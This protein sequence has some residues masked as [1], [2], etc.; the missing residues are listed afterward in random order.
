MNNKFALYAIARLIP[1]VLAFLSLSFFTHIM[2]AEKYALYSLAYTAAFIASGILFSWLGSASIRYWQREDISRDQLLSTVLISYFSILILTAIIF[3]ILDIKQLHLGGLSF[4]TF[5]LFASVSMQY[6]VLNFQNAQEST[7]GYAV[8]TITS[9]ILSFTLALYVATLDVSISYV[10][11]AAAIGLALPNFLYALTIWRNVKISSASKRVG[12][13]MIGY[14]LPISLAVLTENI[15]NSIDR[16]MIAGMVNLSEAGK[17]G[18]GYDLSANSIF[19]AMMIL[20]LVSYPAIMK[21]YEQENKE[22]SN[23][24]MRQHLR[25]MVMLGLPILVGMN[26]VIHNLTSLMIGPE[27]YNSVIQVFPWVST[28]VYIMTFQVFYFNYKFQMLEKT[29]YI[30]YIGIAIAISN[31]LFNLLLIP[32]FQTIGA[33]YATF[34]SMVLSSLIMMLISERLMPIRPYFNEITKIVFAVSMMAL[35]IYWMKDYNSSWLWLLAQI[36]LGISVYTV[37]CLI[38][39][40]RGVRSTLITKLVKQP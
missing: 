10:I 26:L 31:I 6:I 30:F 2:S 21:A 33:A 8:N 36:S 22:A 15:L 37:V 4:A 29:R 35:S 34:L 3:F 11:L 20:N 28:A 16:F 12:K 13:L 32:I 27:F 23:V 24:I 17:Y 25:D 7:N 38:L 5:L 19:M 18:A 1:A 14:G 39:N 9:S 40:V